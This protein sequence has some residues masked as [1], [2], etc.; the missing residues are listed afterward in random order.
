MLTLNEF[1]SYYAKKLK[2][3]ETNEEVQLDA[4]INSVIEQQKKINQEVYN[5]LIVPKNIDEFFSIYDQEKRISNDGVLPLAEKLTNYPDLQNKFNET[6]EE[7]NEE[8]TRMNF[9]SLLIVSKDKLTDIDQKYRGNKIASIR[10]FISSKNKDSSKNITKAL[11]NVGASIN[12]K[13]RVPDQLFEALSKVKTEEE[14]EVIIKLNNQRRNTKEAFTAIDRISSISDIPDALYKVNKICD[15]KIDDKNTNSNFQTIA[16]ARLRS[17]LNSLKINIRK[18]ITVGL[19]STACFFANLY[20][21]IGVCIASFCYF[22][23]E[24]YKKI[25]QIKSFELEN[26]HR[27]C[28]CQENDA[29]S[30]KVQLMLDNISG[31]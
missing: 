28:L 17:K 31:T 15:V 11:Q 4:E 14:M 21:G 24:T 12:N 9:K 7:F 3:I 10:K 23:P 19:F 27:L 13:G 6:L 30:Y 20:F 26:K 29:Y 16:R 8:L 2:H 22:I 1:I 5:S 18:I 25:N